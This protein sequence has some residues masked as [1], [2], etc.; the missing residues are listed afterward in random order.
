MKEPI[1]K[2]SYRDFSKR[3]SPTELNNITEGGYYRDYSKSN[4]STGRKPTDVNIMRYNPNTVGRHKSK[5]KGTFK[6]VLNVIGAA[7]L[8]TT[9]I[10][11]LQVSKVDDQMTIEEGGTIT[12]SYSGGGD[13]NI[14]IEGKK[15]TY[16][17]AV[18]R[19]V[20]DLKEW[21]GIE[22]EYS[23]DDTMSRGQ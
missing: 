14:I 5:R 12:Q 23:D 21:L 2:E 15:H 22:E 1:I 7:A 16:Y 19:T 20:D 4:M 18:V 17:D 6:K 8:I 11:I 13:L 10:F 3:K 9:V